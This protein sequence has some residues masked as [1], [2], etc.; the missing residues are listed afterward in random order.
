MSK[1]R[2]VLYLNTSG[3][4]GGAERC[5]LS[6]LA[7]L[8][9]DRY[10]GRALVGSKGP[11]TAMLERHQIAATMAEL[12][13]ALRQL[14]R[15]HHR[16]GIGRRAAAGLE[17]PGYLWRLRAVAHESAAEII[18]SNGW[19]MHMMSALAR[20]GAGRRLLW[21]L[22]D[23]PAPKRAEEEPL[24]NRMLARLAATPRLL[25]ANSHAV[26]RAY[27]VR[28]PSLAGKMRVVHNGVD[29]EA[30]PAD[31]TAWRRRW[32]L[33]ADD[34][35]VGMVA[36]FAPWKGQDVFLKAAR[37]VIE[38][39]PRTRFVLVGDDIYDTAGHGGRRVE[40]ERLAR[41]LGI[42][43]AVRFT[44]FVD[45][46]IAAA[47]ASLD[48]MVH[49]STAPEPFGRTLIEAMAAG[50]PVIA[51]ND[52]GVQ[53]IIETEKYGLLTPPGDVD[54][55]SKAL[56]RLLNDGALRQRLAHQAQERVRS[57]FSEKAIGDK[58]MAV[59]DELMAG[60]E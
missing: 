42:A 33:A 44:G 8:D 37:T 39:A 20:L 7:G 27:S 35:V 2:T 56:L 34:L 54:A 50:V 5:L 53:E 38:L 40:L 52:G 48:V 15:Y 18:H 25:V 13:P 43:E 59:Y 23:F 45:E 3:Q 57:E 10:R 28:F 26:A 60:P 4:V 12:P 51:A 14:S 19:K 55:L 49:A 6:L 24:S 31:G 11:L 36:I 16:R 58:M 17:L 22:H 41:D 21:H 1:P 46:D 47:Y 30:E 9:Q 29:T 32:G